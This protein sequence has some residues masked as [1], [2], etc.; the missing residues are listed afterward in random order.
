MRGESERV[1][2]RVRDLLSGHA[3][4]L[5]PPARPVP[6]TGAA[7]RVSLWQ[8][9]AARIPVRLDP[10]RR[11]AIG[12]GGAVLIAALVT[13]LW[14]AAQRPHAVPVSSATPLSGASSPVGS[15]APSMQVAPA[16]RGSVATSAAARVVVD[17]A[18]KVRRPG[19]YRLR[20]GSRVYDA[21]QAAGGARP[22]VHLSRLNLAAMV[23]DGQQILVGIAGGAPAP[24][25]A[26][27]SAGASPVGLVDLNTATLDQ[28]DALPG[29]G[30]VTAQY[31]LDW[32]TAHGSFTS[33][34][35]LD[36]VTGIGPA[37]LA[38]LRPLVSI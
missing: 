15:I 27:A 8:Q 33:V 12:V 37:K 13:G 17:V 35:Q 22:G 29:I 31:I 23:V 14:V 19:L 2:A 26:P 30:P 3:D 20:A 1:A 25:S 7:T 11:A 24:A 21:I 32:R 5:L 28:L 36:D 6:D 38:D 16:A 9:M 10:G 34:D 18:G 4:D